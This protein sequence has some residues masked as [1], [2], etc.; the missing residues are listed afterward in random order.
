MGDF[1]SI[2]KV[3]RGLRNLKN[4]DHNTSQCQKVMSALFPGAVIDA[5]THLPRF[6]SITLLC[7]C[8]ESIKHG[9]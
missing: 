1:G 8:N 9:F 6:F 3:T 2:F 5:F 7:L 4:W